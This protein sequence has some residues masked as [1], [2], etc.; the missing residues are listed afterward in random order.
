MNDNRGSCCKSRLLKEVVQEQTILQDGRSRAEDK[1]EAHLKEEYC[2]C[3]VR[4][5]SDTPPTMSALYVAEQE[6]KKE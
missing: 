2:T 5:M 1:D 3:P 6:D 4:K